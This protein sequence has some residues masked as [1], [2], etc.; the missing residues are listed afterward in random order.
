[1]GVTLYPLRTTSISCHSCPTLLLQIQ[2]AMSRRNLGVKLASNAQW[3]SFQKW[4]LQLERKTCENTEELTGAMAIP[5]RD[6]KGQKR[7]RKASPRGQGTEEEEPP[8]N[9]GSW[10]GSWGRWEMS[11]RPKSCLAAG[12]WAG[13]LRMTSGPGSSVAQRWVRAWPLTQPLGGLLT[14]WWGGTHGH[15]VAGSGG[16]LCPRSRQSRTGS[17]W[18]AQLRR[19]HPPQAYL[20]PDCQIQQ[21]L[22]YPEN[23]GVFWLTQFHQTTQWITDSEQ[24]QKKV[25]QVKFFIYDSEGTSKFRRATGSLSLGR[26]SSWTGPMEKLWETGLCSGPDGV[27]DVL[28]LNH[29]Y[30]LVCQLLCR[31]KHTAQRHT[32]CL[33]FE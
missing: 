24:Q 28:Y 27:L 25:S 22:A 4:T 7:W 10:H 32:V 2:S 5:L 19:G 29:W 30:K 11:P 33:H 9:S 20:S 14:R 15:R 18:G 8:S 1:M 17:R 31:V 3:N 21:S 6:R 23:S 12:P 26:Q 16:G 13:V